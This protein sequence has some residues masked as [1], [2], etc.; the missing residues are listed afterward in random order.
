MGQKRRNEYCFIRGFQMLMWI[1]HGR[2]YMKVNLNIV[3]VNG[4][5]LTGLVQM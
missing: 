1:R 3:K 2:I 5:G 4:T